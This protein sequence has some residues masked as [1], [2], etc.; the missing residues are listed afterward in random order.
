MNRPK[1]MEVDVISS[2]GAADPE[3]IKDRFAVVIDVL[4]SSSTLITALANG[5][6]E[7]RLF[8]S[9]EDASEKRRQSGDSDI[10]LC[11]ERKGVKIPGFDLGNSP[12]EY[13]LEAVRKRTLFFTSTNG[14]KM[15]LEASMSAKRVVV[16]GFNNMKTAASHLAAKRMD[17]VLVCSGKEGHFSLED[18]VC[19]GMLAETV[20]LNSGIDCS[21]TDEAS[22]A[23]LVYRHYQDDLAGMLHSCEHG[24]VLMR[25]GMKRDL[26]VCA[27]VDSMGVVPEFLNGKLGLF[28]S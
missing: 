21:L 9:P 1:K 13:T 11:G 5:A 14:S 18:T 24:R 27:A 19:A 2:P 4:R 28:Q 8:E 3:R 12:L 17:C 6:K 15:L 10:L 7:V 25:I 16:A 23:V 20:L 26:A 22:A